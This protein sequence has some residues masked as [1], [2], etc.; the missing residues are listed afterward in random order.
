MQSFQEYIKENPGF[1][2]AEMLHF[3]KG[4]PAFENLMFF[5]L[6]AHEE[7]LP[8]L[9]LQAERDKNLAFLMIDPFLIHPRYTPDIPDEDI[10]FLNIEDPKD[11][12][13]LTIVNMRNNEEKIITANLVSPI[14]INWTD[15]SAKQVI[16]RNYAEYSTRYR[17]DNLCC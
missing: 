2:K 14:L 4:V 11:I 5:E 16:L 7:E 1:E 10:A 13:L 3:P 15:K 17:I 6:V 12:V 9:W 8:F